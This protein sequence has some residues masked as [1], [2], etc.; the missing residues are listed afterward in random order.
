S[1]SLCAVR[2]TQVQRQ[3]AQIELQRRGG[4]RGFG[5]GGQRCAGRVCQG[6]A[7]IVQVQRRGLGGQC[8]GRRQGEFDGSRGRGLPRA[9]R[10]GRCGQGR[11]R[12]LGRGTGGR[13]GGGGRLGRQAGSRGGEGAGLGRGRRGF[14]QVQ[15]EVQVQV[16]Q[17]GLG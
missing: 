7:G 6:Q 17:H 1:R 10:Q 9:A 5:L 12:Q 14:V 16:G 15:I 11:V 2:G 3:V 13:C 8:A 4:C